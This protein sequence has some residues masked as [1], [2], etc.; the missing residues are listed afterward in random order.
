MIYAWY[1][2]GYVNNTVISVSSGFLR[3][4]VVLLMERE[5]KSNGLTIVL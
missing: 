1:A 3:L 4:D 5:T 2:Q